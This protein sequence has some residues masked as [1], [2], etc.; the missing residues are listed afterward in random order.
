[1]KNSALPRRPAL[2]L[3]FA[4]VATLFAPPASGSTPPQTALSGLSYVGRTVL[5]R[6]LELEGTRVGGLSG[7]AWDEAAKCFW[8]ISDDRGQY[9]PARAYRVRIDPGSVV[10]GAGPVSAPAVTVDR[11]LPLSDGKGKPYTP[12]LIDTEG[13]A[14]IPGGFLISTEAIVRHDVQA[15]IGDHGPDGRLRRE[16]ALPS[17]LQ[18]A[19]GHGLR[20]NLGFEGLATTRDGRYLFAG[21]ENALAQDGP[22]AG[23][24]VASSSRILRF[25]LRKKDPPAEFVYVVSAVS[26]APAKKD[27]SGVNGL[28]DLLPLDESRFLVLERQYVEGTGNSVRIYEVSLEGATDVSTLESLEGATWVPARKA[29]LL[30]LADAG[31]P[32]ENFEGMAFGPT[33][34]DGRETLVVVS[35]DNFNAAQDP[36]TFL[37][38]AVEKGPMTVARIQGAGHRSPLEGSWVTGVPGIVTAIDRDPKY[39]GFWLES[40]RPDD[41]PATSEGVFVLFPGAPSLTVGQAVSVSGRVEEFAQ[42]KSLSVTRLKSATAVPLAGE[43]PLPPPVKLFTDRKVPARIDDDGLTLFEPATDAVDFWESLEGM[44]AEIPAGT[45]VGPS[46]SRGDLVIR[47]DGAPGVPRTAVGGVLLPKAG[48]SLDR[49]F[50]GRRISG[51]MPRADVGARI[52]GPVTGIVDY[53]Y[54]NYRFWPL[55]PLTLEAD[56]HGCDASATL[57][58]DRRHLTIASFNVENLSVA[59]P[60]ERFTR[61]G[62]VIAR[63]IGSPDVVALEEVQDD[64][65]PAGKGDGVVTSRKTLD[66]LVAGIA[67]AG[68][69]RYEAAWIDPVEGREG[70]QPGGNIRVA[71]LLNPARVSL[72][73]KGEAGPLDATEPEGLG[74]KLHLTLSPGRVAPRS[75][76]FSPTDGEGVRRSLAV[77]LLFRGK[78]LFVVANHL[79]SKSDDDRA[80]GPTQPPRTPTASRRLAQAREIR[81]FAERLL[82]ADPKARVVLLGDLTDFEDSESARLLGTA[83]LESLVLG[84]PA[85]SRYTFNF[86][87]ASQILD[88]VFVS[89]ALGSGTA[90]EIVHLNSD[91][92]DE[93]R[94][95]DHDP[96]VVRLQVK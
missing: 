59:G 35:D 45:V 15:V 80:F 17:R 32:S 37:V 72:A 12:P 20:D 13:I 54:S 25:D 9:G 82:T 6:G 84:V 85:E 53:A 66:A 38:F 41:V 64:S 21:I 5:P 67:A 26:P 49:V 74:K 95:S 28:S 63:R 23:I 93:K 71:L 14:V 78:P 65:G 19:S 8:A 56:G 46:S 61:I 2:P 42:A 92:N 31:I 48:P 27:A 50:A 69:P 57:R 51:E 18:S 43:P 75:T 68:G 62:E 83:P 60:A 29:L 24:G 89:P 55:A 34:P 16:I 76:A 96:V 90:I 81:A 88:Q 52:R 39:P 91:C 22:V 44:R 33:L 40:T 3:A 7:L 1:M 4:L 58:G 79:S 36:T 10:P 73:K 94:V 70:G 77:E 47:P 30:D 87:G 86:E 11:M